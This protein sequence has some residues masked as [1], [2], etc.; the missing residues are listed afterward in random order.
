VSDAHE[1]GSTATI[2]VFFLSTSL[3]RTNGKAIREIAAAPDAT[4]HHIRFFAGERHLFDRFLANDGLVHAHVVEHAPERIL[5]P[6]CLTV[7]SIAR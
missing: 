5:R 1:D 6:G 7:S 4:D 3:P 2:R